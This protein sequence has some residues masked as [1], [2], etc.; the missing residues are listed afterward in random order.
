MSS[1]F[2]KLVNMSITASYLALG[3]LLL[4]LVFRKMPK[5]ITVLLWGLVG[6]RLL[7]PF[8]IE[9]SSSLVPSANPIPQTI[10]YATQP[11]IQSGI[12][13]VDS[14]V[15]PILSESLAPDVI[16]S[17]NPARVYTDIAMWIWVAGVS[18]MVIYLLYS[19]LK[20]R[21][22]LRE[23]IPLRENIWMCDR[24]PT[25]FLLGL[26]RPRIYV[27]SD[28]GEETLPYVLAHEEAHMRRKDH[29][30]KPLGYLL[31][32]VYWFNPILW[33]A[34]IL[35][36]RDIEVACDESVLREMGIQS[37]KPYSEALLLCSVSKARLAACPLAF[38]EGEVKGRITSILSY[39]K[40]GF[41]ILLVSILITAV[42]CVCFL[43]DPPK[44]TDA[45]SEL[46][47]FDLLH[48]DLGSSG[49]I[50]PREVPG[51]EDL[52]LEYRNG[53]V[54]LSGKDETTSLFFNRHVFNAYFAD[55]NGDGSVELC[56]SSF[57]RAETVLMDDCS[58]CVYDFASGKTY[59]SS[60]YFPLSSYYFTSFEGEI[61]LV[62]PDYGFSTY[63]PPTTLEQLSVYLMMLRNST[64]LTHC[65][66]LLCKTPGREEEALG[67]RLHGV[68]YPFYLTSPKPLLS[69]M[70]DRELTDFLLQSIPDLYKVSQPQLEAARSTIDTVERDPSIL[71]AFGSVDMQWYQM[72]YRVAKEYY[73]SPVSDSLP[74]SSDPLT[75]PRVVALSR[76]GRELMWEDL[77]SYKATDIG[78]GL[79][80][81]EFPIDD[82][83]TL[84]CNGGKI[85]GSP[86]S[87]MLVDQQTGLSMD[88]RDGNVEVFLS[89]IAHTV[90]FDKLPA[91]TV[92]I[93]HP[94]MEDVSFTYSPE[95]LVVQHGKEKKELFVTA[96]FN[97]YFA[98]VTMD[99]TPDLCCSYS[100]GYGICIDGVLIYD[101][102]K[103]VERHIADPMSYQY[104]LQES[105]GTLQV[106][107][108]PFGE[109]GPLESYD[110]RAIATGGLPSVVNI[111]ELRNRYPQ[112]FDLD[113]E[114]G[115]VIYISMI[116]ADSYACRIIPHPGTEPPSDLDLSHLAPCSLSEARFIWDSYGLDS[117]MLTIIPVDT[118]YSKSAYS[119]SAEY[120]EFVCGEFDYMRT[121]QGR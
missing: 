68:L 74:F 99:G 105:G 84:Y 113:T 94:T 7:L 67:Y 57:V 111:L 63:V 41:W 117:S 32:T 35:L 34:Y 18:L 56:C 46:C 6:L 47:W 102:V 93:T 69:A 91:G 45:G 44:K 59:Y 116:N 79:Y 26:I 98:D 77:Y 27:P 42:L 110:L 104:R 64:S 88:I 96:I 60:E 30:W 75:L 70:D 10:V 114:K 83:Y 76:K 66:P 29:W 3:V 58:V 90:W 19:Y 92:S 85:I 112:Y 36:C 103:G 20:L 33:V 49:N 54:I 107:R 106:V 87:V 86:F 95:Q 9:S 8:S 48:G 23:A 121:V 31:L 62:I 53:S 61:A 120:Y 21:H 16:Q 17:V 24:L 82:R 40:P 43:T 14:A 52:L 11:Q 50:S 97:S 38:G 4:R 13:Q 12:P 73:G 118:A 2:L 5:W 51:H 71:P 80:V 119:S 37:K 100:A 115:L 108:Y 25:P 15:N 1:L 55:L 78:S 39:K 81:M 101:P 65:E 89:P 109:E 28:M 72:V 22:N